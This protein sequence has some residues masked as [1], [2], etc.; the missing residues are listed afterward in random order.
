MMNSNISAEFDV[1]KSLSLKDIALKKANLGP[2][3]T[4]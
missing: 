3:K 1:D 2:D 4:E